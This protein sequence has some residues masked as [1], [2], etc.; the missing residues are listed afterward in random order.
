M[1]FAFFGCIAV[2][3]KSAILCLRVFQFGRAFRDTALVFYKRPQLFLYQYSVRHYSPRLSSIYP[4]Q[5]R[6]SGADF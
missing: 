5:G 1:A 4:D 3:Y 2:K 6:W